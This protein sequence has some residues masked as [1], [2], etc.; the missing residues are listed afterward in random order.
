MSLTKLADRYFVFE[1]AVGMNGVIWIRCPSNHLDTIIIRN[2]ILN[3]QHLDDLQCEAMV[4]K[5]ISIS[6][7]KRAG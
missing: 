3:S 6:K 4:D 1:V 7:T 5:I 2:A